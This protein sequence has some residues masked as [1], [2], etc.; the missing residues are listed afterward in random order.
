MLIILNILF[1]FIYFL[2]HFFIISLQFFSSRIDVKKL[3]IRLFI[4]L[5]NLELFFSLSKI[6]LIFT[7]KISKESIFLYL[8][9]FPPS[10]IIFI[11]LSS[12]FIHKLDNKAGSPPCI[13]SVNSSKIAENK[14][15]K[16]GFS[17]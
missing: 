16:K 13:I 1:V 8:S 9:K 14:S 5:I 6:F 4:S 7:I 3:I 17:F 15:N 10:S 11:T 12:K 2:I